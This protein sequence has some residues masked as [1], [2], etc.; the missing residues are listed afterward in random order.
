MELL[1]EKEMFRII[2]KQP[3]LSFCIFSRVTPS[4]SLF[5]SCPC[6][7]DS[8]HKE[9]HVQYNETKMSEVDFEHK[10]VQ[11]LPIALLTMAA[12][13][14]SAVTGVVPAEDIHAFIQSQVNRFGQPKPPSEPYFVAAETVQEL[15]PV[16]KR[17]MS[18]LNN[19][20]G[21]ECM[22][23]FEMRKRNKETEM[24]HTDAG[25]RDGSPPGIRVL[26]HL[27]G[28]QGTLHFRPKEGQPSESVSYGKG[29]IA[30]IAQSPANPLHFILNG[31]L[32]RRLHP[33][34]AGRAAGERLLLVH[35]VY[36]RNPL[37]IDRLYDRRSA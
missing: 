20:F 16:T 3:I 11:E 14:A 29:D 1:Q 2:L 23:E 31:V 34:H 9:I 18:L 13:G 37:N 12:L 17:V 10:L 4:P 22:H 33:V 24:M 28:P 21:D 32:H 6:A 35:D 25:S 15:L 5:V 7:N 30:L 26:Y 8:F 19:A 36:S 27:A